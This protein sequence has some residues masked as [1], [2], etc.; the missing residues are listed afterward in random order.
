MDNKVSLMATL[1]NER[2]RIDKLKSFQNIG[3]KR[4]TVNF[5]FTN[6]FLLN[7]RSWCR[8]VVC[9]VLGLCFVL[10]AVC[11]ECAEQ[12]HQGECTT[13]SKPRDVLEM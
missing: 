1:T 12:G 5:G 6:E 2:I 7:V 11:S 8:H 13:S 4:Q 9:K 3:I 10:R